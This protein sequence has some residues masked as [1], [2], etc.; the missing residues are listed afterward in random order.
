[1]NSE[2]SVATSSTI[3]VN[4]VPGQVDSQPRDTAQ[5]KQPL[6]ALTVRRFSACIRSYK[7]A[8]IE[9]DQSTGI[10]KRMAKV[11][12]CKIESQPTREGNRLYGIW[13][14]KSAV[15][16]NALEAYLF[17]EVMQHTTVL[18]PATLSGSINFSMDN[19]HLHTLLP[20]CL[21]RAQNSLDVK[22]GILYIHMVIFQLILF[23]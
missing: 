8:V 6:P 11:V 18:S 14:T 21:V 7:E 5:E 22:V 15:R 3:S 19:F 10:L 9:W 16:V 23:Q 12:V 17:A 13:M 1:M 4:H 2:S 20:N